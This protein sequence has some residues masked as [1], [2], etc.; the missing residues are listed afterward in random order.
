M[1]RFYDEK[2]INYRDISEIPHPFVIESLEL[3][4]NLKLKE[5]RK[6]YFIHLNHTNPLLHS[7][8]EEYKNVVSKGFNVANEGLELKL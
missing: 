2:E 6:I 4:K 8:S 3:F 1:Q 5:K 7:D